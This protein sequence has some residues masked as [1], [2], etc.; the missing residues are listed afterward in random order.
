M[1]VRIL[2]WI[3]LGSARWSAPEI[4]LHARSSK[5]GDIYL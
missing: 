4:I 3:V 5:Y 1:N 2:Q